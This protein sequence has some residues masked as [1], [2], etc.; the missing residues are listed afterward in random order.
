MILD[1]AT[2]YADPEN[3]TQIQQAIGRLIA[4]KTLIVVA[5]R[6]STIRSAHQILVIEGGRLADKGTHEEFLT[7]CT[8]YQ[9]MWDQ[10][11]STADTAEKEVAEHV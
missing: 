10:Y 8:L 6:L 9:T 7:K 5:H 4:G 1:E 2:A 11:M 3:E